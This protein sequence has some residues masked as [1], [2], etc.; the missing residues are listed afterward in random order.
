MS[1]ETLDRIYKLNVGIIGQGMHR[2]ER[3]HKPVMLL[4]VLDLI[5]AGQ[6]EQQRIEWS[7][8]L[9]ERFSAYFGIVRT[10][11]D[12]STPENPFFHLGSEGFWR[13]CRIDG[14]GRITDL[15][16]P[17]LGGDADTG[18]VFARIDEDFA[19]LNDPVQRE[20]IRRSIV[21]RYFS[22]HGAALSLQFQDG[23]QDARQEAAEDPPEEAYARES[24]FRKIVVDAYDF[25][26]AACGLRIKLPPGNLTFVDAA[27]IIPF[28]NNHDDHPSN[29]MALCKN[30]HWAMDRFLIAP[31][32]K[33]TWH[34]S[35]TLVERRSPG[36][37]ELVRL[38]GE[39][40]LPP[41]ESI[42][43]PKQEA[44]EWRVTR[45]RA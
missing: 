23:P 7:R 37:A 16:A 34:V 24:A 3:P 38:A 42:Y 30:H 1:P 21:S 36:E 18:R 40:V 8:K 39:P 35:P 2:H 14:S 11:L 45:L 31:G 19:R 17:P 29:G 4:A 33:M 5:A 25:Q 28:E 20:L 22:G 41:K 27:H 43:F 26:C 44:L 9:R 32:P 10:Q 12:K 6:A 13:P 15:Q